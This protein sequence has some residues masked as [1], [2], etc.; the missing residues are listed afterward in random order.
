LQWNIHSW[1]EFAVDEAEKCFLVERDA[2][3]L[4][5]HFMWTGNGFFSQTEGWDP[6]PM[7]KKGGD[8][9]PMQY[10]LRFTPT[11]LVE[12]PIY[13]WV[14]NP[15]RNL[16]VVL[17]PGHEYLE[18]PTVETVRDGETEVARFGDVEL[19]VFQ[20]RE[21]LAQVRIGNVEYAIGDAGIRQ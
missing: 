4:E 21:I 15:R 6:P 13:G 1:N 3:S 20:E 2:A 19:R 18:R 7:V 16:G 5:G 11:G 17:C 8:Q 12:L 9:W 10:N 14:A